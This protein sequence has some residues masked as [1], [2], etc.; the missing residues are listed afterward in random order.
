MESD[1]ICV[2]QVEKHRQVVQDALR[3]VFLEALTGTDV[4]P[5]AMQ[6]SAFCRCSS[7]SAA[8]AHSRP[9]SNYASF[10]VAVL[11]CDR[12]VLSL[13]P[14]LTMQTEIGPGFT[15]RT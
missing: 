14:P 15:S 9:E 3:Q 12:S 10:G 4:R 5:I 8:F 6:I 13:F 7:T 11:T 1:L 2:S